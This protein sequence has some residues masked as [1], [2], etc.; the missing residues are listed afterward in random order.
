LFHSIMIPMNDPILFASLFYFILAPLAI[1]SKYKSPHRLYF[2]F[3]PLT[4][5]SLV[6]IALILPE[7]NQNLYQFWLR[8]ALVFYLFG[9]I[10]LLKEKW[11]GYGMIAFLCGH[12]LLIAG[13]IALLDNSIPWLLLVFIMP[14]PV[15][16]YRVRS[17]FERF[18]IPIIF[19]TTFIGIMTIL[20]ISLSIK[21]GNY[22][23]AIAALLFLFSDI[24]IAVNKFKY[25]FKPAEFFIL[26]SYW[27]ALYLF[28][29]AGLFTI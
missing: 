6:C 18:F 7:N 2:V 13:I 1:I 10:F 21:S 27:L 17:R 28:W 14:L 9:D 29:F 11:F 20:A 12:L 3:K 22:L 8:L 23:F 24:I 15:A 19:Y 4:T 25:K 5:L 26:S 16:V